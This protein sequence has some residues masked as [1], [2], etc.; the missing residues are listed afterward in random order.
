HA[1]AFDVPALA[2]DDE[3]HQLL[4]LAR[5]RDLPRRRRLDVEEAALAKLAHLAADLHA[6]ATAVDEVE[7]VL[8][9]VEVREALHPRRHDDAVHADRLHAQ[10]APHLAVAR[11]LAELVERAERVGH[12]L[13]AA[14]SVWF[15]RRIRPESSARTLIA[16]VMASHASACSSSERP[17]SR[18]LIG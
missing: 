2:A 12:A 15:S 16:T 7:L 9:V 6:R 8:L 5:V 17:R 1:V 3:Q 11:P 13:P 18:A 10:R 4:R 14:S